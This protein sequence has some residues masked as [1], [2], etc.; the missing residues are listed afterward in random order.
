[1]MIPRTF[2]TSLRDTTLPSP[3][4][5]AAIRLAVFRLAEAAECLARPRN[6]RESGHLPRRTNEKSG[7]TKASRQVKAAGH[8]APK[9]DRDICGEKTPVPPLSASLPA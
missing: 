2:G 4:W 3:D 8:Q 6:H 1:M 7:P 9:G 5:G